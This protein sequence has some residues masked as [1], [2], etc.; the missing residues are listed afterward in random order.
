M[1]RLVAAIG[2][3]S[4]SVGG[5]A[6]VRVYVHDQQG[7]TIVHLLNLN[8]RRLSSIEDAVMPAASV[9]VKVRVPFAEVGSVTS[10]SADKETARGKLDFNSRPLANEAEVEFILKRLDISAIIEI[11][12]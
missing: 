7:R 9:H 6:T 8:V 10:H 5:P 1:E 11:K 12:R 4:V 2:A 3:P